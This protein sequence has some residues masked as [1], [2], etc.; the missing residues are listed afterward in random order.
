LIAALDEFD[1]A[2]MVISGDDLLESREQNYNSPRDN[3]LFELGLFMGRIGRERTFVLHEDNPKLK[4]PSDLAGITRVSYRI[5]NGEPNVSAA[6]T[7]ITQAI[8][9][10][11]VVERRKK[12]ASSS[13][14]A[15]DE[16]N[17][18]FLTIKNDVLKGDLK[19][20]HAELIQH[21][22][23]RAFTL[24]SALAGTQANIQLHLQHPDTLD[25]ICGDL[26]PRV[27]SRLSLYP[28]NLEQQDYKGKFEIY[29]YKT[30]AAFNGVRLWNADGTV[31]MILSWYAYVSNKPLTNLIDSKFRGSENPC[32]LVDS[33]CPEYSH[34]KLFFDHLITSC[35]SQGSPPVFKME[36]GKPE[37]LSDWTTS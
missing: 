4:L 31:L 22:S 16:V 12:R 28:Q 25:A 1:F 13:I 17:S 8:R 11:G 14:R 35:K 33:H 21:S 26:K 18:A 27:T 30:P 15:F 23:E 6:C 10:L 7:R 24:V 5:R 19:V 29:L 37:W 2:V 9:R 34:F 32:L 36:N 3:V 20:T